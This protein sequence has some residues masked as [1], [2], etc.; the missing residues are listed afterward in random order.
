[1]IIDFT[2]KQPLNES[3]LKMIGTWSKSLLKYMYG[4]GVQV[5]AGVGKPTIT[6]LVKEE[7]DEEK[8][9]SPKFIIRGEH[10]DVK[11]YAQA[12]VREKEY[13]DSIV[14]HGY[15]HL[16]TAKAKQRLDTAVYNFEKTTGLTW[17]FKDEG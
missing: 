7:G 5:I 17:P 14:Q 3:W 12:I 8:M 15:E 9:D 16:Q 2:K 13:I 4:D 11:A 10:K 1:M 6:S